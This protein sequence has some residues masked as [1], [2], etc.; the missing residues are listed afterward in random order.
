[1]QVCESGVA[2]ARAPVD[3][4]LS[5]SGRMSSRS[6]PSIVWMRGTEPRSRSIWMYR[7]R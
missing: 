7:G 2:R 3:V 5:S 6:C 4:P 1:M